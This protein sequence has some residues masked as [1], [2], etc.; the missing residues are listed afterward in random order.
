MKRGM[1]RVS[2]QC[3]PPPEFRWVACMAGSDALTGAA[4]RLWRVESMYTDASAA[5]EL[6]TCD[7][8]SLDGCS[9]VHTACM[10]EPPVELAL[11]HAERLVLAPWRAVGTDL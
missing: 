9:N 1:G 4:A 10:G 6:C 5:I 2:T 7:W 11:L 8:T 3:S